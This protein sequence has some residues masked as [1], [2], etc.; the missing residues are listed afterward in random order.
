MSGRLFFAPLDC[1]RIE[2]PGEA[3]AFPQ[4]PDQVQDQVP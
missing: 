2:P 3:G 4:S 1:P